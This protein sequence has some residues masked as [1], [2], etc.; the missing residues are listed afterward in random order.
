M[1][2]LGNCDPRLPAVHFQVRKEGRNKGKWFYTCQEKKE[3]GCGFFLWDENASVRE[4][5]AVMNNARTEPDTL[6]SGA[7]DDRRYQGLNVSWIQDLG[8]KDPDSAREDSRGQENEKQSIQEPPKTPRK[9]ARTEAYT[10]PGVKRKREEDSLLTPVTSSRYSSR[11]RPQEP[12]NRHNPPQ[13]PTPSRSHDAETVTSHEDSA[14]SYDTTEEVMALLK[15][16][17]VDA[18]TT[19]KLQELLNR[20]ALRVSGI[21]RGRDITRVA[22]KGKDARIAELQQKI[23]ALQAEREMDKTVIENLKKEMAK[24]ENDRGYG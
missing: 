18:E 9:A 24:S 20:H 19:S 8:K 22:L 23:A 17:P 4:M 6:N 14:S 7:R 21:V 15:N 13:T 10:T 1:S 5:R 3:D 2:A 11:S 12:F 16:T